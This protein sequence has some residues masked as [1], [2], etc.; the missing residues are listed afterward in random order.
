M[1]KFE[2]LFSKQNHEKLSLH[3][4]PTRNLGIFENSLGF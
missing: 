1:T 3:L 2:Q 4:Q